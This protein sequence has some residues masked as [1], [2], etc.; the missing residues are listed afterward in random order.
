MDLIDFAEEYRAAPDFRH[1]RVP[2]TYYVPG[3]GA[4]RPVAMVVGNW[5]SAID[6]N[7]RKALS[8]QPG[9]VLDQLMALAGLS[10]DPSDE[11]HNAYVTLMAKYKPGV[12]GLNTEEIERSLPWVR[13]EWRT[14]RRPPVIITLGI[15]PA[16]CLLGPQIKLSEGAGNPHPIAAG[17]PTVWPMLHPSYP[18][19]TPDIRPACERHWQVLG[20]W[21][22]EEGL[23]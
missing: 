22:K 12:G 3:R 23:T 13:R 5:P 1:L 10:A 18:L 9:R 11:V 15:F 19:S 17:G 20:S 21:L 2:F 14:L 6:N 4:E 8:G 16:R 7:E